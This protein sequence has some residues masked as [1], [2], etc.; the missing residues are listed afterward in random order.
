[1]GRITT[2]GDGTRSGVMTPGDPADDGLDTEVR[3][4]RPLTLVESAA[5]DLGYRMPQQ[6]RS[7]ETLDRFFKAIEELLADRTFD[8][9]TIADIASRANRTVGSF[10]ARFPD[11]DA[12]LRSLHAGYLEHD[13]P[14]LAEVL[15]PARWVGQ[16]LESVLRATT[17]LFVQAYRDPRPSF[18]P[19]IIRA[20]TDEGFW[21]QCRDAATTASKSWRRLLTSRSDEINH[22]DPGHAADLCYRHTFAVL[23]H[24]LLLGRL[25]PPTSD[26]DDQLVDELVEA[27]LAILTGGRSG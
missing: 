8:E 12:A 5:G 16:S 23:D 17:T 9:L 20:A 15:D 10:Y 2:L 14:Y 13:L 6:A 25:L 19:V 11:K 1:M 24:E 22:P 7:R 18:R 26:S 27:N 4:A 3:G 21:R